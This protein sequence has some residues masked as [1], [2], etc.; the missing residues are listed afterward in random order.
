M[1]NRVPRILVHHRGAEADPWSAPL[2]HNANFTH[3]GPARPRT[4]KPPFAPRSYFR[5]LTALAMTK[6]TVRIAIADCRSMSSFAQRER[7]M[8]SVGLKA[9][10]LVNDT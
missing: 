4:A 10:A 8:V 9:A 7:G 3:H 6:A 2:V 1:A 5:M